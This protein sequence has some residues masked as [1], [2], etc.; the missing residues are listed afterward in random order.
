MTF[1]KGQSRNP[2]GKP[3]G[4]RNK[5]TLLIEKLLDDDAKKIAEKAIELVARFN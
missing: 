5:A 1:K 2:A 3:P 4:S